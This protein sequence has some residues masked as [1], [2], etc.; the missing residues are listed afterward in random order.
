MFEFT[1]QNG[2]RVTLSFTRN[3]F[4]LPARHV[5]VFCRYH[6]NWLLTCHPKRGLECPGGKVETGE[7]LEQ[8]AVRE[9]YEETGAVVDTLSFIGEYYVNQPENP[10]VKAVFFAEIGKIEKKQHYLETNGPT[11]F[12]QDLRTERMN[13]RFS[14]LMKD[15]VVERTLNFLEENEWLKQ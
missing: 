12:D 10:F 1:D 8:A 3:A 5:L 9:V 4:S 11:L 14:F 6:Q 15:E 13:P 7:T 2:C